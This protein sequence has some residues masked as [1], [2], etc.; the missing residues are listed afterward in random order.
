MGKTT[1]LANIYSNMKNR[2]Y[3]TRDQKYKNWGGRGITVC[4]EWLNKEIIKGDKHGITKGWI[5]FKEWAESNGYSD[6]LTLDRIDNNKGY[7]PENCRWAD[8]KTQANNK[9]NNVYITYKGKTQ[10]LSQWCEELELSR[11]TVYC[12]IKKFH[13]SPER[14]LDV[15]PIN[16][17]K[18]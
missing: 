5:A 4:N 17:R 9:R 8:M 1:R 10:T 16:Y 6:N 18:Y 13:W 11:V 7:S 2:C 12:R 15:K 3:N 14:A